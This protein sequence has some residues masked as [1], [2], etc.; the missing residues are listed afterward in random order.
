MSYKINILSRYFRKDSEITPIVF[1][2]QIEIDFPP[3]VGLE[4]NWWSRD[5]DVLN[6]EICNKVER[7]VYNPIKKDTTVFC[8]LSCDS[9]KMN[10][11]EMIDLEA[12]NEIVGILNKATF[13]KA[14]RK[15][16]YNVCEP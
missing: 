8:A 14:D 5:E 3:F 11:V 16:R 4:I 1:E 10:E 2:F 15:N 13:P 12:G 6:D 9:L 7:I